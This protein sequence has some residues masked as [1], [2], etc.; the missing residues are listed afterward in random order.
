[1]ER[2]KR[3]APIFSDVESTKTSY[4]DVYE[5]EEENKNGK[6][7]QS[8]QNSSSRPSSFQSDSPSSDKSSTH[9]EKKRYTIPKEDIEEYYQ[10]EKDIED[11]TE[12]LLILERRYDRITS[13]NK[14]AQSL[15]DQIDQNIKDLCY[16][17]EENNKMAQIF[18][19]EAENT[20]L[21]NDLNSNYTR[22]MISIKGERARLLF[23]LEEI[24][25]K[26]KELQEI[27]T[28]EINRLKQE[29]KKAQEKLLYLQEQ[30]L[31]SSFYV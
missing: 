20:D 18:R 22:S 10:K 31:K 9:K 17:R 21:P 28:N 14:Q 23:K 19:K 29:T 25:N 13:F 30:A 15:I 26:R 12:K 6:N 4:Y 8:N 7:E 3:V 1:M 16:G 27:K 2:F 24:E 5:E 11:L